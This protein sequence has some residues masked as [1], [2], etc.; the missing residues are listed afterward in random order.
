MKPEYGGSTLIYGDFKDLNDLKNHPLGFFAIDQAEEITE[1]IWNFLSGRL[2]RKVPI[3]TADFKRQYRV[4]GKKSCYAE[5]EDKR[6]YAI[7]GDT[8]CR[9]CGIKLP[10]FSERL[11]KN[12][13]ELPEDLRVPPWDL[14]I[15][16]RYGL[17]V[18]NPE[19]TDHW[20]YRLFPGQPIVTG[21]SL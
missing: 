5:L 15:Y 6:H 7:H 14:I 2:R 11:P 12:A 13:K 4:I 3:L 17:G 16:P 19:G 21:K 10:K 20:I 18:C 9:Y 1:P 8:A